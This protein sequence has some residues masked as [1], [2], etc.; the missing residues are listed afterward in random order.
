MSAEGLDYYLH[1]EFIGALGKDN[2]FATEFHPEKSGGAGLRVIEAF[3]SGDK[4][5][6]T[7]IPR[8]FTRRMISLSQKVTST[9][10]VRRKKAVRYET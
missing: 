2:V 8:G 5:K 9:M 4:S 1:E 7:H 6:I 10:F 3:L